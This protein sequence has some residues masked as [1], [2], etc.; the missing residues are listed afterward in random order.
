M[1]EVGL[2]EQKYQESVVVRAESI[3]DHRSRQHRESRQLWRGDYHRP[4]VWQDNTV[5]RE[6]RQDAT[7]VRND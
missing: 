6:G 2:Q 5:D 1:K 4:W 7:T 3:S